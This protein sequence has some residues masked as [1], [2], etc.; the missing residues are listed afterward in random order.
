M[1]GYNDIIEFNKRCKQD[2]KFNVIH[3]ICKDARKLHKELAGQCLESE[4]ITHSL[5]N[6]KPKI[7]V[8]H[9]D[10]RLSSYKYWYTDEVLKYVDNPL[11][12]KAVRSSIKHSLHLHYLVYDYED[13]FDDADRGRIRVLCN[14]IWYHLFPDYYNRR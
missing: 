1:Q 4:C 14:L 5:Y 10:R 8:H 7:D 6:T 9:V 3:D 12:C 11:I 2:N 13:D